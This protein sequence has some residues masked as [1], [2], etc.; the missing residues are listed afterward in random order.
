M[1]AAAS[2]T[3]SADAYLRMGDETNAAFCRRMAADAQSLGPIGDAL[4]RFWAN[5]QAERVNRDNYRDRM[6]DGQ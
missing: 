1:T 6:K 5:E 4:Y 2:L 3:L